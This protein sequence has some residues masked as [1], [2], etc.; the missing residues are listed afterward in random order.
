MTTTDQLGAPHSCGQY[1]DR[2]FVA[3]QSDCLAN[4]CDNTSD[5][6]TLDP[7]SLSVE[8]CSRSGRDSCEASACLVYGTC[9]KYGS[10]PKCLT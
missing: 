5:R 1:S 3:G 9:C 7:L 4:G 8:T 2:V 6:A 10:P